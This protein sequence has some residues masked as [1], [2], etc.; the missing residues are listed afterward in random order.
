MGVDL[1]TSKYGTLV[2]YLYTWPLF[3]RAVVAKINVC[4]FPWIKWQSFQNPN[5]MHIFS[6][7]PLMSPLSGVEIMDQGVLEM[8]K[9]SLTMRAN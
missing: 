7:A 1:Y 6:I 9:I 5:M 8:S 2:I 4:K 3:L